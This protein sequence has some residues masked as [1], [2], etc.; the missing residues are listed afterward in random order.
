MDEIDNK[1]E[2]VDG[3]TIKDLL[4]IKELTEELLRLNEKYRK[5]LQD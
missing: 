4:K 5:I 2:N 3:N 1:I